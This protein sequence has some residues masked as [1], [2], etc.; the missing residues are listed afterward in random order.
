MR[1]KKFPAVKN[2]FLRLMLT[3]LFSLAATIVFAQGKAISGVVF[4]ELDDPMIGV[5]VVV[6]G[7]TN[8]IITDIDGKFSLSNVPDNATLKVSFIGYMTQSIPVRGKTS[9]T[10]NLE[11]D[12]LALEEVVVVGYGVQR[13]SDVTGALARVSAEEL[14]MKPVSNAF[15]AM[16]GKVAG[17]DITSNQRPG[18]LGKIYIRGKRSLNAENDPLYVVDGIPLQSGGIESLNPRDIESIDILKDASATAIYGSRGANGV[19]LVTTKRGTTGKLQLNYA[20]SVTFENIHDLTPSMKA[21][22]YITWRRWAYHNASPDLYTPGNQ[23]TREQD[24]AFFG[25]SDQVALANVMRGW[26]SGTW[27][28][29]KVMNT[30]WTDFVTQ[31]GITHEHSISAS[32]GTENMKSFLSFGYLNNQGTQKGQEYE[33]YNAT[34]TTDITAARWLTLGGSINASLG[35]QEYGYSRTGQGSNSGPEHI[36]GQAK[37]IF[38]HALPYD[39]N[40]DVILYPGSSSTVYTII[41]E[42]NKSQD[43]RQTFRA[44][45]SFYANLDI[46]KIWS[47]LDGL[48]YRINFGPDFRYRRNGNYI[49]SS[50]AA[51]LGGNN[52]VRWQYERQFSWTL[53]NQVNYTKQINDHRFTVTLVQSASS[54]NEEK[55]EMSAENIPKASYKWNNMG[56]IDITNADYKAGMS[57]GLTDKKLASYLARI[58][59]SLKDK[60]LL[61]VS[62][63]YDGASM[64]AAGNKWDFFPSGALAWRMDQEDFMNEVNWI[65]QLKLRIGMGTVGNS[66]IDAYAT[67][68]NIQSFW[69]P[70]GGSENSLAYAT[71]E[72]YCTN[73]QV[74]MA[75]PKLSWEKTTSFNYGIDYGFLKGRIN[76]A[77]EIYHSRTKDLLMKMKIPTLT[78]YNETWA[79]VGETK[80]LG[81]ELS[82]TA[83][84]IQTRDF[85]W[86]STINAAYQKDEI[87]S[88][89]NGKQDMLDSKWL[90]GES[91]SIRYG[92]DNDGLWQES[93]RAE[94]EKFNENGHSFEPGMVKPIDQNG[95]YKIDAGDRVVL[96]NEN[97][98]WTIGWSNTFSYKGI[99]LSVELFGR[100]G[101]M[102][103]SGGEGQTGVNN[104]REIDYWT[105]ANTNADWQKPIYNT[106]G[107]DAYSSLLG[108]KDA[109]FI[110]FRNV[111]VGY[112]FPAKLCKSMNISNLKAYLQ[113]KNPGNLYSSVDFQDLDMGASFYN[114]G[115]TLGLQVGF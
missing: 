90:I 28:P 63:R 46:G 36:Y 112:V 14:T 85:E 86:I 65:D 51:R 83:I 104:Q 1:E 2:I 106:S 114:R 80:N 4:D 50:S 58:N 79:N 3:T 44:L 57:T 25:G 22:D 59:Y 48:S 10:I 7:T 56:S 35:T 69:V 81:V 40:G 52:W 20:G 66:A 21:A 99:E 8:G 97:P 43:R 87:V 75:N 17:V 115:F 62:G 5:N 111:S 31:T 19:V 105:P 72:P 27:D 45:G 92:Y 47:V 113:L 71:N 33:R 82:L 34:I 53:D 37:S 26:A 94:M 110:K 93:D 84:P 12:A 38:S 15:E 103:D 9:F 61:T 24:E 109:S 11:E 30:D 67:L 16:Q 100:M 70:F 13:K 73:T 23:P 68:G 89:A 108:F 49:D 55:G 78:G 6:D 39:D 18:E 54:W 98:R 96:G 42:W 41:D 32:G 29:S 88:L 107:G 91:I 102:I 64:L 95:D 77:I 60:Y 101:Y 76:G 74:L